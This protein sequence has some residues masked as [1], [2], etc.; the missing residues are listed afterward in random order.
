MPYKKVYRLSEDIYFNRAQPVT[1]ITGGL[2]Y[3]NR[4]YVSLMTELKDVDWFIHMEDD[5]WIKRP[6]Q[7]LPTTPW[8]GCFGALW[9]DPVMDYFKNNLEFLRMKL[10][11]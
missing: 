10:D 8:A 6:I 1:E 11:S 9:D 2:R 5:V 4:I 3:L 7:N